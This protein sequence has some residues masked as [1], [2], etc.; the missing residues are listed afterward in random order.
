MS[1]CGDGSQTEAVYAPI[2]LYKGTVAC[3]P[4]CSK[5]GGKEYRALLID[6]QRHARCRW[7]GCPLEKD[8]G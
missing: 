1:G 5:G 6:Q 8:R 7:G 4:R 3:S 2:L